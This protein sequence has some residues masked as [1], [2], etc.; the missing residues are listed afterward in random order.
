MLWLSSD[1]YRKRTFSA[2]LE[3]SVYLSIQ[4]QNTKYPR[5]SHLSIKHNHNIAFCQMTS[6]PSSA[7]G[8]PII[9]SISYPNTTTTTTNHP[10]SFSSRRPSYASVVSGTAFSSSNTNPNHNPWNSPDHQH[11]RHLDLPPPFHHHQHQQPLHSTSRF[12]PFSLSSFLL[13]ADMQMNSSAAWRS[14]AATVN[15]SFTATATPNNTNPNNTSTTTMTLPPYSRKF[16]SSP[17]YYSLDTT[18]IQS[19]SSLFD[20][21]SSSPF[22]T[23]SYLRNSSYAARLNADHQ[24][25]L[26]SAENDDAASNPLSALSSSSNSSGHGHGHGHGNTG[27]RIALSHRGMTHDVIE[28]EPPSIDDFR[29]PLP[30]L[31]SRWSDTDKFPTLETLHGGLEV[32]YTGPLNKHDHE[33]AAVRTDNPMPPQCGIYYFEITILSKPKEGYVLFLLL[34]CLVLLVG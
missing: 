6:L 12:N 22:F 27:P 11:R 16:A 28:R 32:R 14:R 34:V 8:P 9:T 17:Q 19:P 10:N 24:A 30:L 23:P 29:I 7:G 5:Y 33:A 15:S 20:P 26:A 18:L 3:I 21:F 2:A 1:V 31:P 4:I 13:N 25:R